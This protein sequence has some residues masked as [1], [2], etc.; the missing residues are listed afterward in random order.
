MSFPFQ[1][2]VLWLMS[3]ITHAKWVV[4]CFS[5]QLFCS[6]DDWSN[7]IFSTSWQLLKSWIEAY[8]H[9]HCH[10]KTFSKKIKE[11]LLNKSNK[12]H[13][14]WSFQDFFFWFLFVKIVLINT[15]YTDYIS[16]AAISIIEKLGLNVSKPFFTRV[17]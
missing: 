1:I 3:S 17:G 16:L 15:T 5:C 14:Y 9:I 2:K 10:G 7:P 4:G 13:F 11:I 8:L 6:Q 12:D